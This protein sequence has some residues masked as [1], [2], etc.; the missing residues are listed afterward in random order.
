MRC[1]A[2]LKER[3]DCFAGASGK[4]PSTECDSFISWAMMMCL[5]ITQQTV[6]AEFNYMPAMGR[7]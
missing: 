5:E 3:N 7:E 6:G 4:L 1:L 2:Y